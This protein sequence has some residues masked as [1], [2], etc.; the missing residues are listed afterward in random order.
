MSKK[1][2]VPKRPKPTK[3]PPLP[4]ERSR[5]NLLVGFYDASGER[6]G[7]PLARILLRILEVLIDI[8]DSL[9]RKSAIDIFR[10][11]EEA[12]DTADA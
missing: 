3:M 5:A 6:R 1:D 9:E 10:P 11:E 12:K 2:K 8:R 7:L 4:A